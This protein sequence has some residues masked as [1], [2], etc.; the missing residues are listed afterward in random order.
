[1]AGNK[2]IYLNAERNEIEKANEIENLE[3][4]YI[5]A[6]EYMEHNKKNIDGEALENMK[7]KQQNRRDKMNELT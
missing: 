7:E 5:F 4:N 6:K 2:N 1:M 3:K